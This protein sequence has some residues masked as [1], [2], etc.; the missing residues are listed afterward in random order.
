MEAIAIRPL[1]VDFH[2]PGFASG[3]NRENG[4]PFWFQMDGKQRQKAG[5]PWGPANPQALNRYSYVRNNPLRWTDPSGHTW[6]LNHTDAA[7]LAIKLRELQSQWSIPGLAATAWGAG[8]AAAAVFA[9]YSGA[10]LLMGALGSTASAIIAAVL[11][12]AG[13]AA[14]LGA[15]EAGSI[16]ELIEKA[17]THGQGVA[18]M[19][20]GRRLTALDRETGD[21]WVLDLQ[22][23]GKSLLA[24]TLTC[25][26]QGCCQL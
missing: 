25:S 2:E 11:T 21:R 18:L 6:Y 1:T 4:Q 19:L 3:L 23:F 7:N 9:Q 5:S 17:N 16:A 24:S 22:Y 14:T 8:Q 15:N 26:R 13:G 10:G 20:D 12:T